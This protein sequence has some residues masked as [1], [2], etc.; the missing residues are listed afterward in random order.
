MSGYWNALERAALGTLGRAQPVPHAVHEPDE[1]GGTDLETIDEERFSLGPGSWAQP[2]A[3]PGLP[4]AAA[5]TEPPQDAGVQASPAGPAREQD[6]PPRLPAQAE[7][8]PV[9]APAPEERGA[10]PPPASSVVTVTEFEVHRTER[11]EIVVEAAPSLAMPESPPP[12]PAGSDA[13]PQE[14]DGPAGQTPAGVVIEPLSVVAAEPLGPPAPEAES[15]G[16]PSAEPLVP[17]IVEID[18][19]EVRILSENPVPAPVSRRR[20]TGAALALEEYLAQRSG[21]S[22]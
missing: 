9:A 5:P 14:A 12:L 2:Q 1:P 17:L 15:H 7:E 22:Q 16:S 11:R 20:E 4:P 21:S 6:A 18:R 19:I 3:G 10:A 8:I 13:G